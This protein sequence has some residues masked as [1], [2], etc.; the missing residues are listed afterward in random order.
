MS[1]MISLFCP[2]LF[3]GKVS[4]FALFCFFVA[5]VPFALIF[6]DNRERRLKEEE[7]NAEKQRR[8]EN[9]IKRA[10]NAAKQAREK[11]EKADVSVDGET[12]D[13]TLGDG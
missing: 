4:Y 7:E 9:K 10:E 2:N 3:D 1:F 11:A 8:A 6:F 5:I 13:K 12:V